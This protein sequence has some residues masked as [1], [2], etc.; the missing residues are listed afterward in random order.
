MEIKKVRTLNVENA[1][2]KTAASTKT[3]RRKSDAQRI[4]EAV[5]STQVDRYIAQ[6]AK[7]ATRW[8]IDQN[9]TLIGL[10]VLAGL[11]FIGSV[12]VT[13]DGTVKVAVDTMRYGEE[14]WKGYAV[15]AAIEVAILALL[16]IYLVVGSRPS[17]KDPNKPATSW[18]WFVAML[19]FSGVT[20]L[21]QVFK[22]LTA[23]EFEWSSPSMYVGILLS[24]VVPLSYV[25]ISKALSTVVFARAIFLK[26]GK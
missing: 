16:V 12:I 14:V 26:A 1:P 10:A 23:W 20:V 18:G 24:I 13:L 17:E 19:A 15:Y 8:Q 6:E 9:G 25:L 3:P 21:S 2:V 11:S 4:K 5:Q 7:R 22:V